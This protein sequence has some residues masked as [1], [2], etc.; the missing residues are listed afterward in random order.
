LVTTPVGD[1]RTTSTVPAA[2]LGVVTITEVDV[3]V[4]RVAAVPPNVTEVVPV[5]P[6]PVRVTE[7]F[8]E[9]VPTVTEAEVIVGAV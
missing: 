3:I 8:P 5:M 2:W 6:V 4:P 1:V 7:V 9:V